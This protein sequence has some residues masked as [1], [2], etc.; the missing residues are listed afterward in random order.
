VRKLPLL[1]AIVVLILGLPRGAQT[2]PSH[3][4][5]LT[6]A[7]VPGGVAY[8]VYRVTTSG[9]ELNSTAN[10]IATRINVLTFTDITGVG[11]T[12]Y[13]YEVT[14]VDAGGVEGV[15]SNEFSGIFLG[16]LP[17]PVLQGVVN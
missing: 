4:I 3:N 10:Q 2:A 6:W 12:K 8:N 15:A 11:G 17:A 16:Q 1:L 13:F 9:T 14:A 5:T 7:A